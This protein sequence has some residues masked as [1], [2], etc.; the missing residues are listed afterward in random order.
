MKEDED[1]VPEE[2]VTATKKA[3]S[4]KSRSSP[5]VSHVAPYNPR[6]HDPTIARIGIPTQGTIRNL[7]LSQV[8]LS[9][10]I[11]T[12]LHVRTIFPPSLS[13]FFCC[14]TPSYPDI[15]VPKQAIQLFY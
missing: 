11:I 12:W 10:R 4:T 9:T 6:Y 14:P 15:R 7:L 13:H 5:F 3:K 8:A 2:E 1:Y